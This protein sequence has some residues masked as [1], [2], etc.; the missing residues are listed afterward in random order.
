MTDYE[1]APTE[2]EE[3]DP[4]EL[5]KEAN[6]NIKDFEELLDTLSSLHDRK[7]ALWKQIYQNSVTDRRNAYIAF[8][9]LYNMVHGKSTEHAIHGATLSKYLERMN[10]SNEQL[11]RLAE[12]LDEAI[13]EDEEVD[14]TAMYERV[15][16]HHNNDD[17]EEK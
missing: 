1:D 10:K 5:E 13:E 4:K 11:I 17:D 16:N 15:K 6:R 12:L 7:K 8:G 9:N 3:I 2:F 14:Q